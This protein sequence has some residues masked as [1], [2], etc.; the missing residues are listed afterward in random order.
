MFLGFNPINETYLKHFNGIS[1]CCRLKLTSFICHTCKPKRTF[2]FKMKISSNEWQRTWAYKDINSG[3]LLEKTCQERHG[4]VLKSVFSRSK[5]LLMPTTPFSV[6]LGMERVQ[7]RSFSP[8]EVMA[9]KEQKAHPHS[10]SSAL[11]TWLK[12]VSRSS[13]IL[14]NALQIFTT[15]EIK[16]NSFETLNFAK[17]I[18]PFQ[19]RRFFSTMCQR[20]RNLVWILLGQTPFSLNPTFGNL[21]VSW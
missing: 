15:S 13:A 4:Q 17:C 16:T 2:W 10:C 11:Q 20:S 18:F 12:P 5:G 19:K 21:Q 6:L 3:Q 9:E 14:P 7:R 1:K 8:E